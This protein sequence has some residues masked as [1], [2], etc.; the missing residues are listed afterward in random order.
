MKFLVKSK[1]KLLKL[2]LDY[3]CIYYR[4]KIINSCF[5]KWKMKQKKN[6][7]KEKAAGYEFV[8]KKNYNCSMGEREHKKSFRQSPSLK[9]RSWSFLKKSYQT[10]EKLIS[11]QKN[12]MNNIESV[13]LEI[14]IGF[15]FRNRCVFIC[16]NR[17]FLFDFL[18]KVLHFPSKGVFTLVLQDVIINVILYLKQIKTSLTVN[19]HF[20]LLYL[21]IQE[22]LQLHQ[23]VQI[24]QFWKLLLLVEQKKNSFGTVYQKKDFIS[25]IISFLNSI[26]HIAC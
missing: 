15:Y 23:Q 14:Q 22:H 7:K 18:D 8:F 3:W 2:G 26:I 24:H 12:C 25:N 21:L 1:I 13:P 4:S 17:W 11:W 19:A 5:F 16:F 6:K 10:G 9:W 20:F